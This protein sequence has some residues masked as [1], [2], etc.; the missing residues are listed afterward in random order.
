VSRRA[1]DPPGPGAGIA[2]IAAVNFR[3][4]LGDRRLVAVATVLPVVLILLAGLL[5]GG[6][7]VPLGVVNHGAGPADA[8]LL[9]ILAGSNS[10][11]VRVEA[12]PASLDDDILRGRVSA[13]LVIPKGFGARR[14]IAVTLV[15]ESNQTQAVQARSAVLASL[16]VL[17]AEQRAAHG[18][19]AHSAPG[20]AVAI[21]DAALAKVVA[22]APAPMSPFSYVGPG[23]LVLFAGIT[24]LVLSAGLVES[25]RTGM[26]RRMLA[27][28]LRPG[29]V[30]LGQL[31]SLFVTAIGQA[32]GLLLIGRLVFGV[33]WGDP[34]GV[35][36]LVVS[37]ALA[38]SG[39]SILLGTIVRR[40]EAAVAIAVVIAIAGGMLGGC[41]WPLNVVGPAMRVAGHVTPQAWAMDG[42]VDLVYNHAGVVGIIPDAAALAGFAVVL[43]SLAVWRL[44]VTLG[45]QAAG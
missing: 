9:H 16:D 6:T 44:R 29:T 30:V 39:A 3:R 22:A 35:G 41:L 15:E 38:L 8:R 5:A 37:L 24:L 10:V 36:L 40:Q 13:G 4:Q 23:D 25:R 20:R 28:P 1:P 7:R 19:G 21:T 42:F 18:S 33:R 14:A 45:A 32:A 11:K 27:A 12:S 26:L 34:L 31:V 2:A 17:A 43:C